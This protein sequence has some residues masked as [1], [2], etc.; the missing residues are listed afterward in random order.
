MMQETAWSVGM[1]KLLYVHGSLSKENQSN[2]SNTQ[3]QKENNQ[4]QHSKRQQQAGK[5]RWK[6]EK[7]SIH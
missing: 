5:S 2:R 4:E 7:K 6:P 3:D 1:Q